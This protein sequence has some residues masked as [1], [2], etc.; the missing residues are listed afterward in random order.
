M[1]QFGSNIAHFS[2]LYD[3]FVFRE[4]LK[5]GT[6]TK[7]TAICRQLLETVDE[8]RATVECIWSRNSSGFE[9]I[10]SKSTKMSLNRGLL[11]K[12]ENS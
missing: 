6:S 7:S 8:D 5:I 9:M 11:T 1:D 3:P 2:I 12:T 4:H 10:H